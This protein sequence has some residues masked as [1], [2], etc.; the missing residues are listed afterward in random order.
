ML[1]RFNQ[2]NG[3]DSAATSYRHVEPPRLSLHSLDFVFVSTEALITMNR[4]LKIHGPAVVQ[5]SLKLT[6]KQYECDTACLPLLS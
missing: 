4:I 3:F 5:T 2:L 6:F 1:L